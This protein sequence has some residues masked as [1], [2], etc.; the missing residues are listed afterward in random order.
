MV[1]SYRL[2]ANTL[3]L[4]A[5]I[6]PSGEPVVLLASI[7]EDTLFVNRADA[8]DIQGSGKRAIWVD[9]KLSGYTSPQRLPSEVSS[10]AKLRHHSEAWRNMSA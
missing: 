9:G 7:E 5:G 4:S 10:Q 3:A 2:L 6:Q 1:G 8:L